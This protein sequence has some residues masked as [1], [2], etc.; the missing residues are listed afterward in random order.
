MEKTSFVIL[1]TT[2]L[3]IS[4][5]AR[6]LELLVVKNYRDAEN[7]E[8]WKKT[9]ADEVPQNLL[10]K[11][12]IGDPSNPYGSLFPK[13][14]LQDDIFAVC[15]KNCG[16]Q[17]VF[18]QN[19]GQ[20]LK[21][22][23]QSW[24]VIEQ[25]TV[26]YWLKKYFQFLDKELNFKPDQFL[27]VVTN[28]DLLMQGKQLRNNAFF[29]PNEISLTFLPASKNLLFKLL[30]GKINRSGYDPSVISHEASHYF[31]HHLLQDN[32]NDEIDGVNE[33]FADYMANIFLD[34][35]KVGNVM[36]QGKPIRD[37][38]NIMDASKRPKTYLPGLEVHDLGERVAFALWKT[39]EL[40]TNKNEM[41]RMVIDAV[42]E[43]GKNPYATAHD[44]SQKMLERLEHFLPLEN[45]A[46]ARD[47]WGSVFPPL[48]ELINMSFLEAPEESTSQLSLRMRREMPEAMAKEAGVN[49]IQDE[50]ISLGQIIDLDERYRALSVKTH[51]S[52]NPYWITVDNIREIIHGIY[53][54]KKLITTKEELSDARLAAAQVT[55]FMELYN[56]FKQRSD[57]F[58]SL[59]QGKGPLALA[60]KISGK[61]LSQK[62]FTFNSKEVNGSVLR[63][64]LKRKLIVGTLLGFPDIDILELYLVPEKIEGLS[65]LQGLTIIGHKLSLKDGTV[66][67]LFLENH[68]LQ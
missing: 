40:T 43:L 63:L 55:K 4:S 66:A 19:N 28:K 49:R 48:P 23:Q 67:E 58:A 31:F 47:L 52:Q 57:L 65:Q 1:F 36:L 44:F 42:I 50:K 18:S 3:T 15:A 12:S 30:S 68:K 62:A 8:L 35:P 20:V 13:T 46:R 6:A 22:E 45:L 27:K 26:Y 5:S 51:T 41:D 33:G 9:K 32:I 14:F 21:P 39:R 38:S 25:G 56:E 54:N 64:D 7:I 17:D 2:L 53:Q 34:Y 16:I 24:D 11:V 29:D 59:A 10:S 61:S 37:S 60:L